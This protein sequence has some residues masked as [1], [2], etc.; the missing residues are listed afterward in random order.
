MSYDTQAMLDLFT[1]LGEHPDAT[2]EEKE[3]A[4]M[5]IHNSDKLTEL[6][7]NLSN[8]IDPNEFP[9]WF[10]ACTLLSRVLWPGTNT[11]ALWT[12]IAPY[13]ESL[14]VTED[15]CINVNSL[16]LSLLGTGLPI[17]PIPTAS[18]QPGDTPWAIIIKSTTHGQNCTWEV[19][20]EFRN[21]ASSIH[22][23]I[24]SNV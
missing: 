21:A 3:A 12:C 11:I 5:W 18:V 7:N 20:A 23:T 9:L 16:K 17:M 4:N 2:T 6:L 1:I 14:R 10:T 15:G 8:D 19:F 13:P 22:S 24:P